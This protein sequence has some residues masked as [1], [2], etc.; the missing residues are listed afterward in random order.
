ME[1]F[2]RDAISRIDDIESLI[3]TARDLIVRVSE[4]E[5]DGARRCATE[6]LYK[7]S[8]AKETLVTRWRD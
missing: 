2:Q 1:Q 6:T 5:L 3:R 4:P 8:A 7:L